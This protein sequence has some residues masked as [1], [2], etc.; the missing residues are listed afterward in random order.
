MQGYQLTAQEMA[1]IE[2]QAVHLRRCL[3]KAAMRRGQIASAAMFQQPRDRLPFK[4]ALQGCLAA[5]CLQCRKTE[6]PSDKPDGT[7]STGL[8][9]RTPTPP[10]ITQCGKRRCI[11]AW[12]RDKR[13][14]STVQIV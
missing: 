12:L 5:A 1:K 4:V 14:H 8:T 3:Q 11:K 9:G 7:A 6:Q 2:I 10:F 13:T